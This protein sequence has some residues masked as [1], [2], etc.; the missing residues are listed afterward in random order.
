MSGY[1]RIGSS[2]E[3][4]GHLTEEERDYIAGYTAQFSN[5]DEEE[6]FR[7]PKEQSDSDD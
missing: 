5:S 7:N 4:Y 2:D 3:D 6:A 1:Q